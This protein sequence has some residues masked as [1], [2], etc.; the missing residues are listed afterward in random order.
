MTAHD[1]GHAH[2]DD[3]F[4]HTRTEGLP[5]QE[6]AGH[7]DTRALLI[8]YVLMLAFVVASVI[9][10]TLF[11]KWYMLGVRQSATE[12]L[13][14]AVEANE[15][16]ARTLDSL[17]TYGWSGETVPGAARVPLDVARSRVLETYG[18]R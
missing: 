5:Q 12:T 3:W 14:L 15:Y 4:A 16:K 6:H 8:F 10:V 13:I 17:E 2:H 7:V 11:F 9:G 1:Q 18:S